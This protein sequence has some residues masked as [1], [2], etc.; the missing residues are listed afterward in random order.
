MHC[1]R[2]QT[3]HKQGD[4]GWKSV[5]Y[6]GTQ[7][8]VFR[9]QY[10]QQASTEEAEV[11][12]YLTDKLTPVV[13]GIISVNMHRQVLT[14][15]CTTVLRMPARLQKRTCGKQCCPSTFC[16]NSLSNFPNLRAYSR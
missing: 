15:C 12:L 9:K 16:D 11:T 2:Q 14:L 5:Q 10:L 1:K 4:D 8:D 3:P 6:E 13:V 7:L